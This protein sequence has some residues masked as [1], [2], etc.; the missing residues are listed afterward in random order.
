MFIYTKVGHSKF[1]EMHE[2]EDT[3]TSK[4][5]QYFIYTRHRVKI[6]IYLSNRH[7]Q[8]G[9]NVNTSTIK[10]NFELQ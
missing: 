1:I 4:S 7:M 10:K 3:S 6:V 8:T 5:D 9:V 2:P